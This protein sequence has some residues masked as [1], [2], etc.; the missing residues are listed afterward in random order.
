MRLSIFSC[1]AVAALG[2]AAVFAIDGRSACASGSS[3]SLAVCDPSYY[4]TLQEKAWM[5][6]QREV[7]VNNTVITKPASVLALSCFS[8][9][10]AQAGAGAGGSFHGND[11]EGAII[12]AMG[13]S[14]YEYYNANFSD[15]PSG[16]QYGGSGADCT[17]IKEMWKKVKC[18]NSQHLFLTP[19]YLFRNMTE[20]KQD[21]RGLK[22]G[23]SCGDSASELAEL[24]TNALVSSSDLMATKANRGADYYDQASLNYCSYAPKQGKALE[25]G[26]ICSVDNSDLK[27]SDMNAVPTGLIV[28]YNNPGSGAGTSGQYWSY[29]CLNP[30]CYFDVKANQSRILYQSGERRFC[31]ACLIE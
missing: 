22:G 10:L 29:V 26:K 18:S 19:L 9:Q 7:Q 15:E 3:G 28:T 13:G 31:N 11:V 20:Y 6:V 16:M 14:M 2:A 17:L 12:S 30:G 23:E 21:I 27:C 4:Q 25:T 24:Y 5:E 8:G 1:V